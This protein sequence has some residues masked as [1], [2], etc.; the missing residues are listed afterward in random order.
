MA[1][2]STD[3]NS[4]A[5]DAIAG[6]L[7]D[8]VII[9]TGFGGSMMALQLA[10]A[11]QRVLLL[12]RGD[13]VARDDSAWDPTA[14]LLDRKY[15]SETAVVRENGARQHPDE[16]VGGN[17]VIYGTASLRLRE[18]DFTMQSLLSTP[19]R[20]ES[21]F[22]DWP[23][24]YGD[25]EP[26][27][28]EAE[29]LL[30]VA[31][32]A[33]ADPMESPRSTPYPFPPAPYSTSAQILSDV[34]TARGLRPFPLPVAINFSGHGGRAKCI[35]CGTCDLFPCKLG[36]KN[37]LA[38]TVLPEAI[39]LG[40]VVR[41][42]TVVDRLVQSG[43]GRIT[44][45]ECIDMATRARFT[46]RAGQFV[47]SAG[48]VASAALLLRSGLDALQPHGRLIGR[49]L[50]VHC[51]GVAI[52]VRLRQTNPED[53]FLK[54]V[55][56][57]DFYYGARGHAPAHGREWWGIIQALQVPPTEYLLAM[58][59]FPFHWPSAATRGRHLYALCLAHDEPNPENRVTLHP[60][61]R[62]PYGVALAQV[63]H[64]YSARDLR[65]RNALFKEAMA[66]L[67]K[68]GAVLRFRHPIETL[69]HAVGTCRMGDDPERAVLDPWCQVF[70]VPNLHVVDGSF[71]P[72][73]GAVNPSL[74]IA[75]NALRVGAHL[76]G[77]APS[78][79]AP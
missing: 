69:S 18:P 66:L 33:G 5:P 55:A 51:S 36:A 63:A 72:T 7:W 78:R 46:V 45:V 58:T 70:G 52:G 3:D 54:Q 2:M 24:S 62:D 27:Y 6:T 77:L 57:S 15:Q 48:A 34:A 38:V 32:T 17:S 37:D 39:R 23:I 68:A 21:A 19:E 1:E 61:D 16:L 75:A 65:A 22:V 60:T 35:Q 31:G 20:P 30:G 14:I 44:A 74:T 56:I 11:G 4:L 43:G 26:H 28:R 9:G 67:W 42:R 25:L 41:P 10:R 50:M 13:W 40:A 49:H 47:V 79:A 8:S 76:G 53:R 73:S 71:M 59:P 64:R 12:E 29:E